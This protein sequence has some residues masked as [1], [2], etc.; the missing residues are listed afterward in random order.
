MYRCSGNSCWIAEQVGDPSGGGM[1]G[2]EGHLTLAIFRDTPAHQTPP[3]P[4]LAL[5][6]SLPHVA[7]SSVLHGLLV[8]DDEGI[9]VLQNVSNHAPNDTGSHP[10]YSHTVH[11]TQQHKATLL[12]QAMQWATSE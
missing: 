3:T 7:V 8:P 12:I 2:R 4:P 1:G 5:L 11:A 9:M 6:E 10:Q